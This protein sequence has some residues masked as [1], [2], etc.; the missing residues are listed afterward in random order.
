MLY[1]ILAQAGY[2]IA[3]WVAPKT[4]WF[5]VITS[6]ALVWKKSQP[7][8]GKVLWMH[9][10]SLGE[11]EMG[12]PV[13]ELFLERHPDWK[14]VVTFFSPSGYEP[15]KTYRRAQVFYLPFDSPREVKRWLTFLKPSLAVFV[16]YDLWPNH[17]HG[18]YKRKVPIA[19][20]GMSTSRTP[21]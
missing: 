9:C 5:S 18:L 14:G 10:A 8:Q 3:Q 20:I 17:I 21:W 11:F 7:L 2:K 13:F 12:R 6:N 15:R 19:V 4:S 1:P 16:R